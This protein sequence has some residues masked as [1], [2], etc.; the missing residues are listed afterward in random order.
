VTITHVE[1]A[2]GIVSVIIFW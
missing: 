2:T 1:K